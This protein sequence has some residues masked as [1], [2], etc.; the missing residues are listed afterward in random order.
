MEIVEVVEI[1]ATLLAESFFFFATQVRHGTRLAGSSSGC[2]T[3]GSRCTRGHARILL[4]I[5]LTISRVE[6][7]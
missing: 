7:V 5:L 2:R 1:G 3:R 6:Q 4:P